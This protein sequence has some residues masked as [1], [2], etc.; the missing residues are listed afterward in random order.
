[1]DLIVR[2]DRPY[3]RE[4]LRRRRLIDFAGRPC[5]FASP[6]DTILTKLEWSKIGESER[7]FRDAVGVARVQGNNLDL[8]YLRCWADSIGIR[9]LLDE[10]L[11]QV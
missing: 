2:K 6:E 7:Q 3:S 11:R 5:W 10:L 4:E 1:M 8:E 9:H